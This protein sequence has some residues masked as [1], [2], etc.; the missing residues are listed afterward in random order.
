MT[1]EVNERNWHS[2]CFKVAILLIISRF[3]VQLCIIFVGT[4]TARLLYYIQFHNL[5]LA[6]P[7]Y[8]SKNFSIPWSHP[9]QTFVSTF[10]I[11]EENIFGNLTLEIRLIYSIKINKT[12]LGTVSEQ[13][14]LREYFIFDWVFTCSKADRSSGGKLSSS[15]SFYERRDN[16]PWVSSSSVFFSS[17]R[18]PEL[19][20]DM[21]TYDKE[22]TDFKS[23]VRFL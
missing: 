2:W 16:V 19:K 14:Y 7:T 8:P 23:E 10:A 22:V 4:T 13:L 12:L 6:V 20:R 17:L 1:W 9:S 11:V 3:R 5:W 15:L 18:P 21:A